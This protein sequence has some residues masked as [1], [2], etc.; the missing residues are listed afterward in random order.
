VLEVVR[1]TDGRTRCE[2]WRLNDAAWSD[3]ESVCDDFLTHVIRTIRSKCSS[4]EAEWLQFVFWPNSGRLVVFPSR[5]GIGEGGEPVRFALSSRHLEA[6]HRQILSVPKE[7]QVAAEESLSRR[8]WSR[9][10]KCLTEESAARELLHAR[11]S[12]RLRVTTC[13][14]ESEEGPERLSEDG[15]FIP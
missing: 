10:G 4:L 12:L 7:E 1:S 14:Y 3:W 15:Q 6:A 13:E 2:D 11:R 9:V 5:L 8:V